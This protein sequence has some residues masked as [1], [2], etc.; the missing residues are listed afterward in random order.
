MSGGTHGKQT[1]TAENTKRARP[2]RRRT[3]PIALTVPLEASGKDAQ[4]C[5]F[6]LTTIATSL[7]RHGAMLHLNR[8]LSVDSVVV[9]QNRHGAQISARVVAQT[10][11]VGDL[12]GYGVEFVEGDNIKDFWGIIF[13]SSQARR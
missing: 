12:Y 1:M 8:E 11:I 13:P 9:M 10:N 2:A 5:S 7:N 6:T 3:T 4:R